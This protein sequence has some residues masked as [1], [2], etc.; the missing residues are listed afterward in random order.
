MEET[1]Q[2]E[3]LLEDHVLTGVDLDVINDMFVGDFVPENML[4][5]QG[6]NV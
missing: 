3:E 5:N 2:L 6:K 4:I 1:I